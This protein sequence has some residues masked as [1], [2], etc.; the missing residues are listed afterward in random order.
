MFRSKRS[1]LLYFRVPWEP[2]LPGKKRHFGHTGTVQQGCA[3]MYDSRAEHRGSAN[4]A[5]SRVMFLMSFQNRGAVMAGPT[6][7]I[8]PRYF[9]FSHVEVQARGCGEKSTK[10]EDTPG[11]GGDDD[12][13]DEGEC[14]AVGGGSSDASSGGKRV[15]M[16]RVRGLLTLADFPVKPDVASDD[17]GFLP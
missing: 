7:T 11:G 13:D 3:L 4:S 17:F 14:V 8:S 15:M 2:G 1:K 6:Y 9:N 10:R 5:G 12:D 16:R